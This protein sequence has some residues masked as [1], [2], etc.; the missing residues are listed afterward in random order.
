MSTK[1]GRT[2]VGPMTACQQS[3]DFGLARA[4][5]ESHGWPP[6]FAPADG[7]CCN[8]PEMR[9]FWDL[10]GDWAGWGIRMR[11]ILRRARNRS[12]RMLA[13][14]RPV[15]SR[16]LAMRVALGMSQ[17]Q[18]LPFA[19]FHLRQCG[20]E[21]GLR[22][23]LGGAVGS[24]RKTPPGRSSMEAKRDG[25]SGRAAGWWRCGTGSAAPPLPLRPARAPRAHRKRTKLSCIRSSARAGSAETRAR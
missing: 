12:R 18:Q 14:A 8:S 1:I 5:S 24:P 4:G 3:V 13:L 23:G 25:A 16:D 19:R 17:P 20:P 2:C 6:K 9:S 15:I 21:D 22:I 11:A 7:F 10:D